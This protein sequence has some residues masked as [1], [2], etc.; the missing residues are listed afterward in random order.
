MKIAIISFGHFDVVL[1]LF[2]QLKES[3]AE[4][5]LFLCLSLT[6]KAESILNFYDKQIKAGFTDKDKTERLLG[7]EI[8]NYLGDISKVNFF[9]FHDQKLRSLRNIL[10]SKI[11][12]RSLKT[13]DVIH[14]NGSNGVLPLLI[15]QL[16]KKKFIFTIHDLYS[17]SGEKTKFNFAERMNSYIIKSKYPVILQNIK[18]FEKLQKR[19]YSIKDKFKFIPFG[20]LEIYREF[21]KEDLKSSDSD[22]LFFG[23]ISPYKGLEYLISA[24]K[25]LKEKGIRI[26][27]IIAG[28]GKVYFDTSHLLEL[29]I[30]LINRY[31]P[32]SELVSLIMN[33]KIVV[34]PYVDA[35]QSGVVMTAFAFNKPVIA[36]SVGSFPEV[37]TDGITGA[38]VEPGNC[39]DLA[40]KI[41]ILLNDNGL[42][43]KMILNIQI[44]NKTSNYSWNNI[45]QNVKNLYDSN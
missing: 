19:F 31:I 22:L 44:F 43:E 9:V 39:F 8:K 14:F 26:K 21:I 34:C 5:D 2:K 37:I 17:H 23:R 40:D 16:R 42:R 38:L 4:I 32:N 11:F 33:T 45:A 18:D 24:I 6:V 3:S 7:H 20:V 30:L 1:P 27:L 29:G 15:F 10:L 36:S 13:Y 25:N 35:T 28:G 41:Q 12:S